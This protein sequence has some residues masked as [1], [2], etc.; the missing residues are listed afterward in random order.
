VLLEAREYEEHDTRTQ[1]QDTEIVHATKHIRPVALDI[2]CF[3][4]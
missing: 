1:A 2:G 4:S 3:S